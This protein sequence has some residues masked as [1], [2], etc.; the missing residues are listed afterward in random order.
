MPQ[1]VILEKRQIND[2]QLIDEWMT[3]LAS[4]EIGLLDL[5]IF[6]ELISRIPLNGKTGVSE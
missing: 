5:V 4:E 2:A 1:K 6:D 3:R